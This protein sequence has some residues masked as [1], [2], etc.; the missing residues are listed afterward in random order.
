[1]EYT[2]IAPITVNLISIQPHAFLSHPR[3]ICSMW[4]HAHSSCRIGAAKLP[5]HFDG[6]RVLALEVFDIKN[7]ACYND[8]GTAFFC[9]VLEITSKK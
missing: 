9:M 1:M 2:H 5:Y 4:F 8:P 7:V 3:H 6:T